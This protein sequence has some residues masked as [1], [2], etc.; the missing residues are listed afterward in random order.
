M[1]TREGNLEAPR[2]ESIHWQSESY[3]DP[4][5]V[6]T[7]LERVFD[8]CHGCRRCVS[9]C[10]TFPTLF[11]LVDESDTMEIDGVA[12]ESYKD[13]VSQCYMCDLCSE[14]KCPYLPPHEWAVDFPHLMLRAKAMYLKEKK[15]KF[16]DRIISSTDPLFN[17]ASKPGLA[18]IANAVFQ[19]KPLR[20][21]GEATFGIHA[22][23]PIPRFH[24]LT[25]KR[26]WRKKAKRDVSPPVS[27]SRES[28]RGVADSRSPAPM[29]R[30]AEDQKYRIADQV[31][32][33][34]TCYGD[35]NSPA[36]VDDLI[37]ILQ[38]NDKEV[39]IIEDAHCCGM[40]KF[41]LGDLR[42]VEAKKDKNIPVFLEYAQQGYQIMSVVP[43][44]TLMYRQE[45]PLL[46]PDDEDVLA[47]QEAF[48]DPFEYLLNGTKV[49]EISTNFEK[50]LGR[51][52][53]HAA[54]HQRVQNIGQKTKDFLSLIPDTTVTM[55]DRCSGHGGTH[56]IKKE[57]YESAMKIARPATRR[58]EQSNP[59]TFGSDC[60]IAG[61]LIAH[62]LEDELEVEHPL[63]MVRRAYGIE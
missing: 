39:E 62:G 45:V 24:S 38:H 27:Y 25:A 36:V 20:K 3:T 16:R 14:T 26:R 47:V 37:K 32:I 57:T 12:K 10:N 11:D 4:D 63:S 21:I 42:A 53:Y 23:A 28:D 58:L 49:G 6:N 35:V 40:P 56:A 34:V 33:F 5:A 51:L 59:D 52:T 41:E 2:R 50:S 30:T 1:A 17:I 9:L 13:V 60:P 46:F 8:I 55:I 7:E 61:R 29:P 43:S 48:V 15:P 54:C 44:C 18:P 22:D 19:S 31:A